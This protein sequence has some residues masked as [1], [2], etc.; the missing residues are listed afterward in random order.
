[1]LCSSCSAK[2]RVYSKATDKGIREYYK[3]LGICIACHKNKPEKGFAT[4]PQCLAKKREK[5]RAKKE[6]E[7]FR[8]GG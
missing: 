2:R 4:C 6:F 5:Y 8:K 7:R 3:S 1:M